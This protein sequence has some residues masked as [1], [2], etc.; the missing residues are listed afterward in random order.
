MFLRYLILSV[1]SLKRAPLSTP[2][3]GNADDVHANTKS[4]ENNFVDKLIIIN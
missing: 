4:N 1:L 3:C 2:F